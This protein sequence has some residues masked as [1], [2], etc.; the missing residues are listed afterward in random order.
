MKERGLARTEERQ[1]DQPAKED[2]KTRQFHTSLCILGEVCGR[3][4][5]TVAL[6]GNPLQ[7]TFQAAHADQP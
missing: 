3:F 7:F 6:L 2:V 5:S 4:Y 1:H